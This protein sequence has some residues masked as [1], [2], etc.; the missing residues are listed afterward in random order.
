VRHLQCPTWGSLGD[1]VDL[2]VDADTGLI[3]RIQSHLP[4]PVGKP[5][6]IPGPFNFFPGLDMRMTSLEY[7]P[8]FAQGT[9][10]F[11]P[12]T[13][14]HSTNPT[15]SVPNTLMIGEVAPG[16]TGP[17]LSGGTFDLASTRGKPT[18]VSFWNDCGCPGRRDNTLLDAIED[19]YRNRADEFN[20]VTVAVLTDLTTVRS[21]V[22][23]HRYGFPVIYD[24]DFSIGNAW[25]VDIELGLPWVELLDAE[26]RLVGVYAGWKNDIGT[27][28]DVSAIL[29]AL[30][31]GSP[32]P[33]IEGLSHEQTG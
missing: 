6:L 1:H 15:F 29:Q 33:H 12:P 20:V 2:W 7:N 8:Q 19:A 11:T 18:V 31:S 26:G 24:R 3:L 14:A 32:L 9:F 28:D 21:Y 5:S 23:K 16:W 25:G 4:T 22:A 10:T 30:V 13:G 17:L 27:K